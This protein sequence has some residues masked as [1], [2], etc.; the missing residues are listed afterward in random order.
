MTYEQNRAERGAIVHH[1]D[2]LSAVD[3]L[4]DY[5]LPSRIEPKFVRPQCFF[6]VP[7]NVSVTKSGNI[8]SD[9]GNVLFGGN[10]IRCNQEH[11]A[12]VFYN[13]FHTGD[14]IRDISSKPYQIVF[15]KKERPRFFPTL[16]TTATIP[17]KQFS[18]SVAGLN[19]LL[20][21]IST[22]VR[23][24]VSAESNL[25][26]RLGPFQNKQLI[27]N[28]CAELNY[29]V[30]TRVPEINLTIYAE[31]PCNKL[32]TAAKTITVKLEPCPDGF[33]LV[34]DECTCETDL[35]RY[36][37]KCDVDDETIQNGGNFWAAG[38]YNDSGSYIGIMS[39]PNCP[40][41]YCK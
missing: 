2:T 37:A 12:N 11:A 36:A 26:A 27:N 20:K 21:P 5:S 31:G 15:C 19:Q 32:G 41:D 1:D 24:E 35:S 30:F 14:S 7:N 13:L 9:V 34:G 40:F 4:D 3:C 29:R 23:A 10:L 38:L 28:S 17:G 18:V 25:M 6:S 33:E 39:F 16:S 22:T 8:A